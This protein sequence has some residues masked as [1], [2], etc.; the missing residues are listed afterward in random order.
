LIRYSGSRSSFAVAEYVE[1]LGPSGFNYR[2]YLSP[3]SFPSDCRV[4]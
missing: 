2:E 4:A 1:P 3:I